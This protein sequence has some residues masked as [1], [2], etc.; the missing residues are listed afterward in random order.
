LVGEVAI[1]A[2]SYSIN[3]IQTS[4]DNREIHTMIIIV[5]LYESVRDR[6]GRNGVVPIERVDS[7]TSMISKSRMTTRHQSVKRFVQ[8]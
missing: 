4:V 3:E 6:G 8:P 7:A 1:I 5:L 2:Q